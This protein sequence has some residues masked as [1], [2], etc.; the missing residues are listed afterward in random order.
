MSDARMS[1]VLEHPARGILLELEQ[2]LSE[3]KVALVRLDRDAIDAF[4]ARKLELDI[5]L[6]AAAAQAPFGLAEKQLIERV[7]QAA[8]SN[9]LLLAHARSCVQGVLSLLTPANAPLYTAP[10]HAADAQGGAPAPPIAL[11]LRS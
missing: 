7:R 10:G 11:N 5:V 4:A 1:D 9:Q 8:L 6:K 2:L 3:E